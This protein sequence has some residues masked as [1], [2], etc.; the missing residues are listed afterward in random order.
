MHKG[1]LMPSKR[2]HRRRRDPWSGEMKLRFL[3][4]ILLVLFFSYCWFTQY[5]DNNFNG[6]LIIESQK[7]KGDW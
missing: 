7:N 1:V 2:R 3:G 6:I 4:P 5:M